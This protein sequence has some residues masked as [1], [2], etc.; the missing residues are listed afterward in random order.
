MRRMK[1]VGG[2][3]L[4]WGALLPPALPRQDSR[5]AVCRTCGKSERRAAIARHRCRI[6]A[7]LQFDTLTTLAV[8]CLDGPLQPVTAHHYTDGQLAGPLSNRNDVDVL[9]R[10]SLKQSPR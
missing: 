8:N 6:R 5:T 4:R 1:P 7:R 3:Q 9:L 10:N 2:S